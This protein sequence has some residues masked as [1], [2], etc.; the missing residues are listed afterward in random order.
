MKT[1]TQ[2]AHLTASPNRLKI[3]SAVKAGIRGSG[4]SDPNHNQTRVRLAIKSAIK[5]GIRIGGMSD[6]NHNQTLARPR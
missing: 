2:H 4:L 6:L 5:A 3:K 1:T